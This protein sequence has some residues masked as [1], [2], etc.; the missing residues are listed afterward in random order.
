MSKLFISDLHLSP[1]NPELTLLACDFLSTQSDGLEELYILGDIFNTWLGD[2][3][4][5]EA[6]LPF[7]AKLQQL[8]R[9]GVNIYLMVGN[10]DFMLGKDFARMTGGRLLNDPTLIEI[11]GHR[12]LLMHGD[13][14]CIDDVSYQRYRRWV[15]N[16]FLQW[17]FLKL[18]LSFR[19]RISDKIKQKSRQQKQHKTPM[20]MDVNPAEVLQVMHE[21]QVRLIIHGHTH[22]PFIHE[23]ELGAGTR[24]HRV[25]LGDWQDKVSFLKIEDQQLMLYDHRLQGG[26][27]TLRMT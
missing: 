20:I 24:A 15:R 22:R 17:C 14:L 16:P 23:I 26:Q 21:H 27:A 11:A 8:S 6:L 1:D 7:V 9:N 13:S 12:I 19:Q 4:I 2:D 5:P 25:V 10:R 3:L 18:P